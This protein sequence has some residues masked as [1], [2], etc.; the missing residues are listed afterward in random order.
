MPEDSVSAQ[1]PTIT[2]A[3]SWIVTGAG[4]LPDHT[5][6]IRITHIGDGV[7]DYLTYSTDH[8]GRLFAAL[9]P[10]AAAETSRVAVTDHRRDPHGACGM[11]W[12]NTQT[13]RGEGNK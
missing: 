4:F 9:P 5:V 13:L 1:A 12:S 11:L 2:A 7:S 8:D 6:T 10:G 3:P